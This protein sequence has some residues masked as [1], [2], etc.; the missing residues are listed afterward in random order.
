[1]VKPPRN[2]REENCGWKAK[3]PLF[4]VDIRKTKSAV[5]SSVRERRRDSGTIFAY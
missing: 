4:G 3:K 1:M 5:D 2:S